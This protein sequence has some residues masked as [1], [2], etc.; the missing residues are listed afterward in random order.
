MAAAR[1]R[2]RHP[3]TRYDDRDDRRTRAPG[4][5]GALALPRDRPCG[6]VAACGRYCP[7]AHRDRDR[8]AARHSATGSTWPRC[9][10]LCAA[11]AAALAVCRDHEAA[12][13]P[14]PARSSASRLDD[15]VRHR[16]R[17]I[18]RRRQVDDRAPA[19]RAHEPWPGTPRVELVTT[20]GF[21][22]P[23]AELERRGLMSRK[24][25]PESYDRRASSRSSPRSRAARL[26]CGRPSTRT[27]ATTSFPMRT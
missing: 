24:G 14:T 2:E 13:A 26:R 7:A 21:L 27:C 20:D 5:S 11:L 4:V 12:R 15:A 3:P 17:R 8:A 18:G 6:V 16:R 25:F 22:Y 19:A 10:G 9:R 23:N 1:R